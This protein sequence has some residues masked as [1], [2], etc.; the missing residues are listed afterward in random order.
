LKE[1]FLVKIA[2][3]LE[4]GPKFVSVYGY[5]AIIFIEGLQFAM[6]VC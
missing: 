3:K 1:V 5:C 4:I 6:E 2:S